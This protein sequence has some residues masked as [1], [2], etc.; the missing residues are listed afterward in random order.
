MITEPISNSELADLVIWQKLDSFYHNSYF[1]EA[2]TLNRQINKSAR[3]AN[4]TPAYVLSRWK[5]WKYMERHRSISLAEMITEIRAEIDTAEGVRKSL[6]SLGYAAW[7]SDIK[8]NTLLNQI[9]HRTATDNDDDPDNWSLQQWNREWFNYILQSVELA[10]KYD[11]K[12]EHGHLLTVDG[13]NTPW[14]GD[15]LYELVVHEAINITHKTG[16]IDIRIKPDVLQ[17]E[18]GL[19]SHSP[20]SLVTEPTTSDELIVYLYLQLEEYYHN[21]R[22]EEALGDIMLHRL[23]WAK[24]KSM[25]PEKDSLF[26]ETLTRL[27]DRFSAFP[28]A[29]DYLNTLGR[30]HEAR[31]NTQFWT[32]FR[33][34]EAV[35]ENQYHLK[36]ALEYYTLAIEKFPDGPGGREAAQRL[37]ELNRPHISMRSEEIYHDEG[38]PVILLSYRNVSKVYIHTYRIPADPDYDAKTD[39]SSLRVLAQNNTPVAIQS[40]DLPGGEDLFEHAVELSSGI[41]HKGRYIVVI[42]DDKDPVSEHTRIAGTELTISNLALVTRRENEETQ[43]RVYHR[44][45]GT[46]LDNIT[47]HFF[48]AVFSRWENRFDHIGIGSETTDE[49]G[50][51]TFIRQP[52][53]SYRVLLT[54]GTDSLLVRE[55]F[56]PHAPRVGTP[57]QDERI[58]FFTDRS[59]YRPGQIVHFKGLVV[60]A[61][62]AGIPAPQSGRETEVKLLDGNRRTL[63]TVR[64]PTDRFG[65]ISGSFQ[66]P[67]HV[68]Q[69]N[70]ML[71]ADLRGSTAFRVES[72]R[73]PGFEVITQVTGKNISPGD[74]VL[75]TGHAKTYTGVPLSSVRVQYE[76]SRWSYFFPR[77]TMFTPSRMHEEMIIHLGETTTKPDGSFAFTV[78]A[79]DIP[80]GTGHGFSRLNFAVHTIVTDGTGEQQDARVSFQAG[81]FSSPPA[82]Q[83]PGMIYQDE[84]LIIGLTHDQESDDETDE[85][86]RFR[87]LKL[88]PPQQPFSVR[89]WEQPDQHITGREDFYRLH[90]GRPYVDETD[91]QFWPV[92]AVLTDTTVK[93]GDTALIIPSGMPGSGIYRLEVYDGHAH[94]EISPNNNQHSLPGTVL[95]S[96]YLTI[97]HRGESHLPGL[98]NIAAHL[99]ATQAEPGETVTLSWVFPPGVQYYRA[100]LSHNGLVFFTDQSEAGAGQRI[101][102]EIAESHRGDVHFEI[103]TIANG[104]YY[105]HAGKIHVPWS[106]KKLQVNWHE[107]QDK[108]NPG[109]SLNWALSVRDNQGQ[110]V[111]AQIALSVYDRSLDALAPHQWQRQFF[112]LYH[113]PPPNSGSGFRDHYAAYWHPV[114]FTEQLQVKYRRFKTFDEDRWGGL[115]YMPT[116]HSRSGLSVASSPVSEEAVMALD[117]AAGPEEEAPVALRTEF[118]T[119]SLFTLAETDHAGRLNVPL[120]MQES[121]TEWK[122]LG[123]AQTSNLKYVFFD[124]TLV[125]AKAVMLESSWP[126]FLR[127]GDSTI[128]SAR[129]SNTTDTEVT[130]TVNFKVTEAGTDIP[131]AGIKDHSSIRRV[132]V[133]AGSSIFLELP[134]AIPRTFDGLLDMAIHFSGGGYSDGE[135]R[136][137]PVLSL[138]DNIFWAGSSALA[139]PDTVLNLPVAEINRILGNEETAPLSFSVEITTHPAW[140]ALQSLPAI[141]PDENA[142]TTQMADYYASLMLAAVL[143]QKIPGI[144]LVLEQWRQDSSV[145]M[146]TLER[147][148]DLKMLSPEQIPWLTAAEQERLQKQ[149]LVQLFDDVS[150]PA[151]WDLARSRLASRQLES[152]GFPWFESGRESAVITAKVIETLG[153]LLEAGLIPPTEINSARQTLRRA[154]LF[155]DRETTAQYNRLI[156]R[157]NSIPDDYRVSPVLLQ[158]MYARSLISDV[159]VADEAAAAY[160]RFRET[161]ASQFQQYSVGNRAILAILL[162]KHRDRDRAV[163]VARSIQQEA[164]I[165]PEKGM[166]WQQPVGYQWYEADL[167][168][169]ILAF[170]AFDI[171]LPDEDQKIS[172]IQWLLFHRQHH[173]W[174]REKGLI[175]VLLALSDYQAL[176][177]SRDA[178][179]IPKLLVNGTEVHPVNVEAGSGYAIYRLTADELSQNM[180]SITLYNAGGGMVWLGWQLAYRQPEDLITAYASDALSIQK[181]MLQLQRKETGYS[182]IVRDTFQSGDQVMVRLMISSDRSLSFVHI[183]DGRAAGF[184]PLNTRSD[185]HWQDGLIMYL[186]FTDTHTDIFIENMNAGSYVIEYPLYSFRDGNYS[187]GAAQIISYYNPAI[188][189]HTAGRRIVIE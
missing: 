164:V 172:M 35:S 5:T 117:D 114:Q 4:H 121:V 39:E 15:Q 182:G 66:L 128:L 82:I 152:G 150:R 99:S 168:N 13:I 134:L 63:G 59:I 74:S 17:F 45:Y 123:W 92:S 143:K 109:E 154:A 136:V 12:I 178:E 124:T 113:A 107:F 146:S 42:S 174:S 187:N 1:R 142:A 171:L 26:Y 153:I 189:V 116:G 7:V 161:A 177:Y 139:S 36:K 138:M 50:Q 84:S 11:Q 48:E 120:T 38:Y 137:V 115:F 79:E 180:E 160:T 130:G 133:P 151:A 184:E 31:L 147:N 145:L 27:T 64:A 53:M 70:Y 157:Q 58:H 118:E 141:V 135:Q 16:F 165:H 44:N 46:P 18:P 188:S 52:G 55:Q 30:F 28:I 10:R 176:F 78:V 170:K 80:G 9:G 34:E 41:R 51:T 76:V 169:H 100:E 144:D 75:I 108:V 129:L 125:T 95:N 149:A 77:P 22:R 61:D 131:P 81:R 87:M 96:Q 110:P 14:F 132:A 2:E 122:V 71:Q 32:F 57:A 60:S 148:P 185:Y 8:L 181:H 20:G 25:L 127:Q 73:P 175:P 68:L 43:F 65:S 103:F 173:P 162:N 97:A 166:H 156:A 21:K 106:N 111:Q 163:F 33:D 47:L 119:L 112:P 105:R 179:A 23:D 67:R 158:Q 19:L 90:P 126:R 140:V 91:Q 69:G 85:F 37:S 186:Q 86:I 54:S 72:Y 83:A 40:F 94:K 102:L 3:A 88:E 98:Q 56:Y 167:R 6:L 29:A 155:I 159:P 62:K 89:Y 104:R 93:A 49:K 24:A 101:V 183:R